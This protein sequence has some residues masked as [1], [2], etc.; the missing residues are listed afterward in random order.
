MRF[1]YQ[2]KD[3]TAPA[4]GLIVLQ[5]D[6][7]IEGDFHRMLPRGTPFYV[8]RVPS[9]PDVSS[10]T[11]Q[12]MAAHLTQAATLFPGPVEFATVGYGCTS[13][14]AQIGAQAIAGLIQRGTRTRSVTE[15]LSALIAACQML[16]VQRI[17]ILS[18]YVAQVSQTLRAALGQAGIETPVFGSFEESR[19]EKVVRIAPASITAAAQTLMETRDAQALFLSCTNLRTLDVIAPLER[20]LGIPVLSS[21]QVLAWHMGQ[22]ANIKMNGPGRLFQTPAASQSPKPQ[23]PRNI[24]S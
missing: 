16:E 6:E 12:S 1:E 22:R 3:L 13:G 17:A 14:T 23:A 10:K 7:T 11:L 9:A 2:H 20:T 19:E 18:P 21:N 4:L 8:S 5:S 24:Y 15:P